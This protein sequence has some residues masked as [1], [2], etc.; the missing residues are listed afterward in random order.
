M[1]QQLTG[2]AGIGGRSKGV[3]FFGKVLRNDERIFADGAETVGQVFGGVAVHGTS[4]FSRVT[5]C[6]WKDQG[7]RLHFSTPRRLMVWERQRQETESKTQAVQAKGW[8]AQRA[9]VDYLG[10]RAFNGAAGL[11]RKT[12]S[13]GVGALQFLGG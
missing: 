13:F 3:F 5:S 12:L 1:G 7:L 4:L 8:G 9:A 10:T 2:A 6:P 11:G